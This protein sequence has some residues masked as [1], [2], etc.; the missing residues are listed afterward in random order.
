MESEEKENLQ[1]KKA[2]T[3]ANGF[4]ELGMFND[5]LEELSKL[6]EPLIDRVE[7]LQMKLAVLIEA[8]DW[9]SASCAA[10]NLTL[11]EPNDPGHFVNLAFTTRRASSIENAK[12]ILDE[13]AQRFPNVAII[14]YNLGCY[15]CQQD[16]LDLAKE[17][18]V[19]AFSLDPSFLDTAKDDEDLDALADWLDNL[20]IA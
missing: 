5:A 20:E 17:K 2:L 15:A 12:A 11:R 14:Q 6:P 9:P 1:L 13:A 19:S 3:Y 7:A 16:D 18:L 4:R 8:K 10:K